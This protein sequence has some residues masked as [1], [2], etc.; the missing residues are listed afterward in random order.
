MEKVP[1]KAKL[2]VCNGKQAGKVFV[3]DNL[4]KIVIGR[5]NNCHLQ[6]LD[7]GIS[8][9]HTL[10][11]FKGDQFVLVDLGST[12][13]TF[14][15][16]KITISKV[17][18]SG[19]MVKIGQ[20]EIQY[21]EVKPQGSASASLIMEDDA[22]ESV[23]R[24]MIMERVDVNRSLC[25]SSQKASGKSATE[26]KPDLTGLYLS[27]IYEVSNLVNAEHDLKKLFASIMDKIMQ[28]FKPD[29]GFL[30]MQEG[31]NFHIQI[32]KNLISQ[33]AQLSSTILK[34]TIHEGISVLSAN[35]MLDDRF[36]GGL[37][38]VSQQI[39]SVM[40]VPLESSNKIL[41]AIYV[42]SIGSSNR[43]QKTHLDL[44]AAIGKQA[45]IAIER[46]M[47]FAH[48]MEKEKLKQ[49]LDIA[50]SIQ[51]SLLPS[52]T[53]KN[54]PYDL[55]GWN[56]SC[57]ETGGD[58][59]DYFELPGNKLGIAV[60][61]VSGHGIGAALLMATARAFL[62][63]LACK[64]T[65]IKDV[66]N[67]LN[68]LL[69]KDME[70]DKFITLFYAELD[71]KSLALRYVNAGHE[72]PILYQKGKK[73]F[74]QLESTGMPL[75]MME[76]FEYEEEIEIQI[77]PG[78]ILVLST[79][80]ITESMNPDKEQFGLERMASIIQ[81]GINKTANQIIKDCYDEVQKFCAGTPQRDD[82]TL[83]VL[84][85]D[86]NVED[87]SFTKKLDRNITIKET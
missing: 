8:R 80:G 55:V 15:N 57:D 50:Q 18:Q 48:Y 71:I 36:S 66:I 23:S 53:P 37:S 59:Y 56:L 25:A 24:N 17:L 49:A 14:V 52:S 79:D 78:D 6:I 7:K 67:E 44:L 30:V 31:E 12:N 60:G 43:F 74:L 70:G 20:T 76:D 21:E 1:I 22:L 81:Q 16:N 82:L 54:F 41:G 4:E 26:G 46:T 77:N 29:R 42:D 19:D 73:S 38:I 69:C 64:S 62:K 87:I 58:Y 33:E 45:G 27:T 34:K 84:K 9:N 75:G 61:D 10:V 86:M 28:V 68:R 35:A 63:A 39:K 85:F 40:S 51:K 32:E 11:E 72:A 3:L 5:D 83:V 65:N 47:L 13:G 2:T